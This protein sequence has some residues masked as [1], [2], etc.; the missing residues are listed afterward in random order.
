MSDITNVQLRDVATGALV[1]AELHNPV[2]DQQI[3]D[4]QR[5]WQPERNRR[6]DQLAAAGVPRTEWPQ[7][8]HWQWDSKLNKIQ[9]L[10]SHTSV[11]ITCNGQTQGLM[12]IDLVSKRGH[13]PPRQHLELAY[14]DYLEV[15]PWNWKDCRFDPP[16]Y[17]LIGNLMIGAAIQISFDQDFKGRV[18]L[19]SLPQSVRFYEKCGFVNMG[20]DSA[21]YNLPYLELTTEKAEAFLLGEK[22]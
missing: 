15:A 12:S 5:L 22:S 7:S 19:H 2:T 16:V 9:S 4:W 14:V 6:I 20:P 8:W 10:L 3:L 1:P 21:Y 18:G 17:S 11:A 13:L